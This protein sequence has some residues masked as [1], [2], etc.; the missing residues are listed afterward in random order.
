MN[1]YNGNCL[2]QY[3]LMRGMT[4]KE[5][6]DIVGHKRQTVS[7]WE[8]NK[9]EIHDEELTKLAVFFQIE[10]NA[11][12][13]EYH[14]LAP[15]GFHRIDEIAVSEANDVKAES[16]NNQLLNENQEKPLINTLRKRFIGQKTHSMLW[17]GLMTFLISLCLQT[18]TFAILFLSKVHS[19]NIAF[20]GS[21]Y[22]GFKNKELF[23]IAIASFV[24]SCLSMIFCI[25][26]N[27]LKRR[28]KK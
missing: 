21:N 8:H 28:N 5:I 7:N 12:K 25:I 10:P 19:C 26:L 15:D 22:D 1:N 20:F 24:F 14:G 16:Q 27:K 4:Q 3:R 18:A 9:T 17:T 13:N 23:L 2:R 11:F 6:G